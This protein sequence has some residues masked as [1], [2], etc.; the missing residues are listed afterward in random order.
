MTTSG[1]TALTLNA[2]QVITF[3]LRKL[4][5][6][7]IGQVP[8]YNEI[9]PVLLELNMMLK[10]WETAGPHLWRNTLGSVSLT[11]NTQSYSLVT[12]NPL[13][14]VEVRYRYPDLHDLPMKRLSRVQYMQLPLKSSNGIFAL[15]VL[16]LLLC[17]R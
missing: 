14:L 7:P 12:D 6:I 9:A 17:L 8:D 11:P 5:V 13:R 16:D 1:I 10:G 3:A 4:G 15:V 2:Q